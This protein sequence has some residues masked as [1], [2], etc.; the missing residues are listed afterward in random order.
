MARTVFIHVGAPKTGTTYL[1]DTLWAN[2]ET[3]SNDGVLIPGGR[4]FAAFHASQAIRE[5]RRSTTSRPADATC[6]ET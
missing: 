3:L 2:R 5:V 6:G 1:Q 4:R